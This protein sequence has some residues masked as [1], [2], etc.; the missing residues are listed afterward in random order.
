MIPIVTAR[1]GGCGTFFQ[2]ALRSGING[3]FSKT[4]FYRGVAKDVSSK[5]FQGEPVYVVFQ[6]S[7]GTELGRV[8]SR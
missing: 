3:C 2:S 4:K 1:R 5:V 7:L 6:S 8:G